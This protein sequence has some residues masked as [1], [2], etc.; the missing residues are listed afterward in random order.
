MTLATDRPTGEQ[1]VAGCPRRRA[2]ETNRSVGGPDSAGD[3]QVVETG[4]P[5]LAEGVQLLGEYAGTGY[6]EPQ[7]VARRPG[8][9][10]VQLSRLLHLIAEQC[11]GSTREEDIAGRV[12]HRYRQDGQRRQRAHPHR[13]QVAAPRVSWPPPTAAAP[14][15]KRPTR[16][17]P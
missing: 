11:D 8:G 2:H 15:S 14:R 6:R 16:C 9:Q 13:G 3:S 5:R 10:M 7:Y 1:P 12:S 17:W 4:P